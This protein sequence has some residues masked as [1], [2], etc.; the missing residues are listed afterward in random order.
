MRV[1]FTS[2][3]GDARGA[4]IAEGGL[5]STPRRALESGG[6]QK[7]SLGCRP[8]QQ[9]GSG[10]QDARLKPP[11][12]LGS[13]RAVAECGPGAKPV[14]QA[15]SD[16]SDLLRLQGRTTSLDDSVVMPIGELH[17]RY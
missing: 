11:F 1:I 10:D 3:A 12:R 16:A 13:A 17:S 4:P 14:C 9:A 7:T 15:E 2:G 5:G 8:N 6:Q